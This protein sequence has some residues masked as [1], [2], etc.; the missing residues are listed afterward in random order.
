M[1]LVFD[2]E[3][4]GLTRKDLPESHPEHWPRMVQLAWQ[5]HD[6]W[7]QIIDRGDVL[8]RPDGFDIPFNAQQVH[9]ISTELARAEGIPLDDALGRFEQA[10]GKTAFLVGH[11]LAF[12]L[13]V[14]GAEMQRAGHEEAYLHLET[15]PVLDTMTEHTARLVGIKRKGGFKLPKLGELYQFLFG[16]DFAEAHNAAA[17]VEATAR[18]FFELIRIGIIEP[19]TFGRDVEFLQAFRERYPDVFPPYG[20]THRSLKHASQQLETEKTGEEEPA[21]TATGHWDNFAHLHLYSQFSILESTVKFDELV[22]A[23]ADAGMPAVALTDKGNMMGAFE[24]W[25]A[26]DQYNKSVEDAERKI[27]PVIGVEL[28]VC[29]NHRERNPDDKGHAVLLLA[30]NKTG[31][32]NLVKLV[33]IANTEGY[34]YNPRVDKDLLRQYREG[35]IAVSGGMNGEI[36]HFIL[37]VGQ[38][39]AEE[40]LK[41]WLDIFGE[42]FYLEVL[43]HGLDTEESLNKSL[44]L[45]ADKHKVK[46]VAANEVYYIKPEDATVQEVLLCIRDGKKIHQPVGRGRDHRYA[47]PNREFYLKTP[48]QMHELFGRDFPDAIDNIREI[49]GKVEYYSLA[50]PI[51]VPVFEVP[52]EFAVDGDTRSEEAQKKYLRH[53]V[54]EGARRRWGEDLDERKRQRLEYELGVIESMGFTGYFLIVWDVINK[55]REMGIVVG[56]GRGSAAGSAVSYT[57]GITNVDPIKYDLLFERFLNPERNT[58]PDIDMDFDDIGR[59][60]IVQYAVDKYGKDNVAHIITYGYI[61]D[62]SAIRD[63]FRVLDL[64]LS[65]ANRLSKLADI[66]LKDLLH[67]PVEELRARGLRGD[68]LDKAKKFKEII[69]NNE[70]LRH[71]VEIAATVEGAIRNRSLH[72]CGY[73]IAPQPLVDL[74]PVTKLNKTDL[75][76]TQFDARVVESA[77]LLKMD[78]LAIRTLTIVKDTL[79]LIKQRHGVTI[80]LDTLGFDDPKT[81]KLLQDGQTVGVFQLESAGMRKNLKALKPSD[82]E[83]IVAMVALYRPGPM[84]KIP[85]YI[86]R[87][88]G[89]EEVT[90]DLPEMEEYLKA[91]YGITI[92]QEQVMLLSQKLADFSGAE[93]DHLRK[94]MGKKKKKD[95]DKMYPKFIENAK[96][97]GYP[98]KVLEKIWKD[99]EAF[100]SYAFNRSHAVSYAVL[101]YHTAY[102][103]ANYPA[104]F[105]AASLSN[106]LGSIEKVTKFIQDARQWNIRVLPPDVNESGLQFTVNA[107]GNIRF[108]LS[109]IKGVGVKAAESIIAEREK[110]GPY[111]D[112]YDFVERLDSRAVNAR[113]MEALVL[114]GGLDRFGIDRAVYFCQDKKEQNFIKKLLYYGQKY[115]QNALGGATLFDDV[116]GVELEKPK[117]P[118]CEIGWS[119]LDL[120]DR[121]RDLVG[122]YI[123]GHPLDQFFTTLQ[124]FKGEESKTIN[125]VL[126]ALNEKRDVPLDNT[127]EDEF[128]DNE[129]DDEVHFDYDDDELVVRHKEKDNENIMTLAK[130]KTYLGRTIKMYGIVKDKRELTTKDGREF[131][132]VTLEDFEGTYELGVFGKVFLET[133]PYLEPKKMLAVKA[134]ISFNPRRQTHQLELVNVMPLYD[135]LEKNFN[136]LILELDELRLNTEL[137]D[138]LTALIQRHK[139]K[140]K[141]KIKMYSHTDGFSVLL[142]SGLHVNISKELIEELRAISDLDFNIT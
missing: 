34:Y 112:I 102:L 8:V 111:K 68:T 78:F 110:N 3:T 134:K 23:V 123:S 96:A 25:R 106:H 77:G 1:F 46:L 19:G 108:G 104:E 137:V 5:L 141:V 42:D 49:L 6:E 18:A 2:T 14:V 37:N 124:Y 80:D 58:M 13:G 98:V 129:A 35:I 103:K 125:A 126:R 140:K 100:A 69:E 44:R 93:A 84:E 133:R 50:H 64:P 52:E 54:W 31:Y 4:T 128:D 87:K 51:V 24:F 88:H 130:A 60:K 28:L 86:R 15:L 138:R 139:G 76:V 97:K 83:D 113:V 16:E 91:T 43:R 10:L 17:D 118:D 41:E 105:F 21:E 73:I 75:L 122:F 89:L 95:L 107:E 82:F 38:A 55:A 99:W 132:F 29:N 90:Y 26:V 33:S 101:A 74:I 63:T 119:T 85:S 40:K 56:A 48:A 20:L 45:L 11:N 117:V 94:A 53:L 22:K 57:L 70:K 59:N 65:D 120:L 67:T 39:Q 115:K 127:A 32:H 30:K 61:K 116:G 62:K 92:Y 81:Y 71:G 142:D 66:A 121:E 136:S 27:K 109:A 47:L 131:G 7:G 12:D 9:G 36:A 135:V 79:D 72:A 114:S